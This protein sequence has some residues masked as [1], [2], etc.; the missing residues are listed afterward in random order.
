MT[1]NRV[2]Q[3]K[4]EPF[5][6]VLLPSLPDS[7]VFGLQALLQGFLLTGFDKPPLQEKP[8]ALLQGAF[9]TAEALRSSQLIG[10]IRYRR[11]HYETVSNRSTYGRHGDDNVQCRLC[12]QPW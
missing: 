5:T 2:V 1:P 9:Y 12:D 7:G 8:L 4:P 3:V 10:C 6:W 11:K